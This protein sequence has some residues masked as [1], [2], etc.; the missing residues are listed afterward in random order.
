MTRKREVL[1]GVAVV[2]GIDQLE[3]DLAHVLDLEDGDVVGAVGE[4]LL[5]GGGGRFGLGGA[6]GARDGAEECCGEDQGGA[7][8]GRVGSVCGV[9]TKSLHGFSGAGCR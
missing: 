8:G 9:A 1:V 4:E 6:L 3:V 7:G 2:A 5:G